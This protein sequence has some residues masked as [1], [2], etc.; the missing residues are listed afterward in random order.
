MCYLQSEAETN[1]P[2]GV[3]KMGYLVHEMV[4]VRTSRNLDGG[5]DAALTAFRETMPK[6]LQGL[7]VGPIPCIVN[8]GSTWL[9]ADD[10][11]KEG[12]RD[13][14]DART[15]REKF[16]RAVDPDA[17]LSHVCMPEDGDSYLM[18]ERVHPDD[19]KT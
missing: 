8:R 4:V 15:W 12:W 7:L 14:D 19:V 6:C 17:R 3:K 13:S 5:Q 2:V 18:P 16:V 10:G 1:S 11:S 9:F